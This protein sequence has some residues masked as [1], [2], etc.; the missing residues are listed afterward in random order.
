MKA[1][2]LFRY[3]R[4]FVTFIMLFL[5]ASF[6]LNAQCPTV[7]SPTPPPICDAAGYTFSDLSS[8]FATDNGGGVFWYDSAT[9]GAPFNGTQLVSECTYYADDDTESCVSR[10]FII[11]DFQVDPSGQNLDGIYCSNENPTVQTYIDDVLVANIPSGGSVEVYNDFG[12]TSL[13]NGSDPLSSGAT[14]YFIVFLDSSSCKSQLEIGSTAMFDA[15]SDPTPSSPQLFCSDANPTVAELDP[16][17]TSTNFSWYESLDGSGDPI[18]PALSGTTALVHGKTYYVQLN[19]VFCVS[20]PVAVVADIDDPVEPGTPSSLEYCDDSLPA[21][22]FNLFDEL[23]GTPDTTG[24][25]TGPLTTTNGHLGTVNIST[26]TANTYVFTYTVPSTGFCPDGIATVTITVYETFSSGTPSALNPTSYCES[27][28]PSA[29]DLFTLLDNEDVGGQWTQGTTSSDPIVTSPIDLTGFTTGTY[30]FTYTQ[31][32]TPNPCPEESTT[33]QVVVLQD[34]EAGVAVNQMFCENELT[35]NSLFDLFNALDGS[36]DSGGDWTD[37]SAATVANPIDITGFTV[38]GSPYEYT[39]TVD[40]GTCTDDETIT[41]TILPAPESGTLVTTFP[42]FCEGAAPSSFDLFTLLEGEDQTGSWYIGNDNTGSTTANP[43]DLSGLT[44]ATYNY[45][46]DVD[47]IGTCD[48]VLLTVSVTINPLPITGTPMSETYC[49][50]ELAANSP[51]DLFGQLTGE[52]AGG[53]WSDDNNS[54]ALSGSDVDLTLLTIGSFNYTYSITDANGCSNSSTVT[55]IVEDAPESGTIVTTFPEFCEGEGSSSFDLFTLLEGEDQTGT[56]N[57]DD[58]SGSLSGNLVD[59]SGLT[60]ATY[61]FTFDVDAIGS[62]DDVLVTVSVTINPLPITG[63]P[64]SATFCENDL[65]ANS[66]LDLYGQLTGEDAGG[67]WSDDNTSGALTGSDVDLTLLTI[68]SYNYTYS[69]TDGNGC[70]NSSTVTVIV[71]DAPES[72]TVNTPVEFCLADVTTGQTY[73]LFDLLADEDQTGTWNDDDA[74]S[75]LSGNIVSL[76]VLAEGTFNFTFDVDAIGTCDDVNVTVSIIINDTPAPTA[77]SPQEFCDTATVAELVATGTTI[78]WYDVASGGTPLA[79]TTA[80]I[81][82]QVYYATQT[83]AA[84]GCESSVRTAVT[85]TIFISPIAG[86]PGATPI[87]ACNDNNNIDLF[88]GLDGTEDSG[89]TWQNDDGVGVLTGNVFD[90]TGVSAGTYNFTYTVTASAPCVDDFET[91]AVTIE[92]P[93]NAGSDNILDVCS[94]NG[95]T[96]LFTLIGSADAGGTWSP[97]MTSGTGVF[98]PLVDPDGTYTYTL[99]NACGTETSEVVVTVTLAPNAGSDATAAICMIDGATDLFP[100]LG[101][102]AQSGGT[103]SPALASGTGVF[104]PAVDAAGVYTYTVTAVAPCSPD[105]TAEITVTVNDSPTIIVNDANP[106]YCLADNP[107]VA[108]LASSIRPTGS[109]NWYE[110]AALTMPL[111]DTDTLVDGEDYYATQTTS[112]GCESSTAVQIDVTINDTATPTLLDSDAEYCINDGP[113]I[114]DLS[115]NITEYDASSNNLVWY[116][117]ATDGNTISSSTTLTNATYYVVLVDSVTGCESSARLA[118]APDVTACGKLQIPDGFSPNGDGINDTF[119]VDNLAIL[120]PN[121]EI[122]IFNRNGNIVYKG[123]ANS[124]RFDGTSNQSRVVV[125]GDLPVGVYFYIFTFNDGENKPEQGRLYLSR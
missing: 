92:E 116:D 114:N 3:T 25:W 11:I 10:P 67:T 13:A 63:T 40:N 77:T 27:T 14:N 31:N 123:N 118:V 106:E 53:T 97:A 57:D 117:A 41:I 33:V 69:I 109:V 99:V 110:D 124:Q 37:A 78:Q 76:D 15:P 6:S 47:A 122:E 5:W 20:N 32:L 82:A 120:Y 52:D 66:P 94:N 50:N 84:T 45:T 2:T 102:G 86:A 101:A 105:S 46:Y 54:G 121:F 79:D 26:L 107:T 8:D 60:P 35:A 68:G 55:I 4:L 80:L 61:N 21:S 39:Y 93:L 38:A 16:G 59:L 72:G 119:E 42:E 111:L 71:E 88:T 17:T 95:T 19:D 30:D 7:T 24:S 98:D 1:K 49:E 44:P 29:F 28:L 34:P 75:A 36:Q 73:D 89:G 58:A 125:N 51:L 113:T 100:S 64:M 48:D 62:C 96:D 56:W 74:T 91:I 90:A 112:S 115:L 103:W 104:D 65:A 70:S 23:G 87:V 81:D 83:D 85:A 18:Q 22:D 12:L 9:G 108:D 43:I